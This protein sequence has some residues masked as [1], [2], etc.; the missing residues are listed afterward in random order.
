MVCGG[1]PAEAQV[2]VVVALAVEQQLLAVID[3]EFGEPQ[4]L[5]THAGLEVE[6]AQCQQVEHVQ[7]LDQSFQVQGN[8]VH[9]IVDHHHLLAK[10][11]CYAVWCALTCSAAR[12]RRSPMAPRLLATG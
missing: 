1:R 12:D 8:V 3:E 4:A 11:R 9:G 10:P 2:D 6:D 5:E 7:L